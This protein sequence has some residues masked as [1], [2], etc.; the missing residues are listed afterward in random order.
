[1]KTLT[2]GNASA[3]G[4]IQIVFTTLIGIVMFDEIPVG[5]TYLGGALIILGALINVFGSRLHQ[6]LRRG[7]A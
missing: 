5:W 4:Y 6:L 2:A 3:L 1:M 7:N